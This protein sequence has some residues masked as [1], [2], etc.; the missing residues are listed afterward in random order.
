[1]KIETENEVIYGNSK[2]QKKAFSIA[3]S[4]KAFK[5][6]SSNIYKNKIRAIVR[7]LSCNCL[8][9]H[10]LNGNT[11]PFELT[12]PTWLDQH[13]IVRDFGPGLS[14]EDIMNLYTTYFAS[15]KDQSN[16]FIGA[17]GLGSKS[18]FSYTDIFTVKSHFN[19]ICTTYTAS[20]VNG[21]PNIAKVVENPTS[22]PSGLEIVIPTKP[23]DISRWEEEIEYVLFPFPRDTYVVKGGLVIDSYLPD[24]FFVN[25]YFEKD[26]GRYRYE[27]DRLFAVYGNI[28]YPLT[29]CPGIEDVTHWIN[30]KGK[31][32]YVKFELGSLDIQ[33]SREEL[34]YDETTISNVID[35]ISKF[36]EELREVDIQRYVDMI[37]DVGN[38]ESFYAI[39]DEFQ[40][41]GLDILR[42]EPRLKGMFDD[43][44]SLAVNSNVFLISIPI[45]PLAITER[46]DHRRN[47]SP[48]IC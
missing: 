23:S 18:P 6:L 33:P 1:M 43:G 20:M 13:F 25:G 22:E 41:N 16:D 30:T 14:D 24:E 40:R 8:D 19:G 2:T 38:I 44:N 28:L 37:A 7:E 36:D 45:P 17:L 21:E 47:L 10:K 27:S 4:S 3:S 26:G 42:K 34:S 48:A 32:L 11:R 12:A 31:I 15:T 29:D 5:I 46:I 9:A 35:K 39:Q